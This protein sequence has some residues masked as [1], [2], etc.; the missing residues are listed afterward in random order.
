MSLYEVCEN[1][2]KSFVKTGYP[3]IGAIGST[4]DAWIISAAPEVP[5]EVEYGSS[6]Y[7]ID[8]HTGEIR[9]FSI[10]SDADWKISETAVKVE[11]PDQFKPKYN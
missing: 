3:G 10:F 4:E 11:V 1:L 5:G 2:Y 9:C 7:I 6:P 8:K